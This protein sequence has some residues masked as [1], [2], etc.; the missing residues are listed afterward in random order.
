MREMFSPNKVER[1]TIIKKRRNVLR[2]VFKQG[3]PGGGGVWIDAGCKTKNKDLL[4]TFDYAITGS[5]YFDD[6]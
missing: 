3:I 5:I 4:R 1:K 6:I 2:A